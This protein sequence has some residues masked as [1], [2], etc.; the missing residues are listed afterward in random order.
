RHYLFGFSG[1]VNRARMWLFY[2]VAWAMELALFMMILAVYGVLVATG[3]AREGAPPNVY[4]GIAMTGAVV[5][6]MFLIY[7]VY[8]AVTVKRLHDRNKSAWWVLTFVVAPMALIFAPNILI[9]T[10]TVSEDDPHARIAIVGI[11]LAAMALYV[12]AFVELYCL[13]GTVGD[14]RFGPDP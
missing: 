12:W 9:L 3:V 7:Y 2:V 8:M 6:F 14:N 10:K 4:P 13:R 11:A 5:A 1:R